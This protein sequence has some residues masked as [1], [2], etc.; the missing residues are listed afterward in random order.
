MISDLS[1]Y[2]LLKQ[3]EKNLVY[4]G[5]CYKEHKIIL[6]YNILASKSLLNDNIGLRQNININLLELFLRIF[7]I[8]PMQRKM[9]K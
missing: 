8:R 6:F 2:V 9:V 3:K 1:W 7:I 5:L 4:C